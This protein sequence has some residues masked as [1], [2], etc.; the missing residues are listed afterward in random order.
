MKVLRSLVI[1][2]LVSIL[3]TQ[4][5][6]AQCQTW[7]D[8]S[9]KDEVEGFH[10]V[11]RQ[12]LKDKTA[13]DLVALDQENFKIAFDAWKKAYE[14]AP[15]ADGKRDW[16]FTDGA[17]LYTAMFK[18]ESDAAKKD[19]YAQKAISLYEEAANCLDNGAIT[20]PGNKD[21]YIGNYLYG[22]AG[23]DMF[24]VFN[25]KY[26]ETLAMLQKAYDRAGNA[27][28]YTL[29]EPAAIMSAYLFDKE[30]MTQEE[31]REVYVRVTDIADHNIENNETYGEYYENTKQR[32][33]AAFA[34]VE[35][36]VFDCD[37]FKEKLEPR[38]RENSEDLEVLK[39]V[40]QK[41]KGQGCDTTDALL[42]E[43]KVQYE[44]LAAEINKQL[45]AE[46]RVNNPCYD[47]VQLQKE[48]NYEDA[49]RRYQECLDLSD[50]SEYAL[51]T[52]EAK[53]QI[54]YSMANIQCWQLGQL[55]SARSNTNRAA[56][57]RSGWGKPYILLGD[58]YSKMGRSGC[59]DWNSRLA[60]LAA[61][62]KYRYAKSIDPD[63]TSDANKR[64][65]NLSG[66]LPDKAEGFMR[67]VSE[68]QK[69]KVG[70]GI[71]ETVTIRFN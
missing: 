15:A 60:V 22:Q 66:A 26:S 47:A 58:I 27:T 20:M 13:D 35:D 43:V 38:Y 28:I 11:Y 48:G 23:F 44:T 52:D 57:M 1:I 69:V 37:Y 70:C 40:Y 50:D 51:K 10:S 67:K 9:N 45:E 6:F 16:H 29:L 62:E 61:I 4:S 53:A 25:R 68:G 31:T 34:K 59:D 30:L 39:Y 24:Y 56:S 21:E 71:G 49:M 64:I 46:R 5:A 65:N 2:A 54:Y 63:V 55:S 32:M 17:K 19:E 14:A 18:K 3:G 33:A 12:F 8:L 36:R 41:L 42:L 7:A